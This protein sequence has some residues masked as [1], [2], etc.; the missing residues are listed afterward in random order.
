MIAHHCDTNTILK[1]SFNT[2]SNKHRIEAYNSIRERLVKRGHEVNLQILD[3]ES[4]AAYK[5]VIKD[6]WHTKYQ[7]VPPYFHLCNAAEKSIGT[8]KAHF[9]T[10]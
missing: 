7:L 9:W 10:L 6:T 4:S 1:A 2:C 5:K 8:F 3:N